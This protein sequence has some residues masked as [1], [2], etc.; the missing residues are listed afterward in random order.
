MNQLARPIAAITVLVVS[1]VGLAD[2]LNLV[3]RDPDIMAGFLTVDYQSDTGQLTLSGYALT[4]TLE[5][6]QTFNIKAPRPFQINARITNDGTATDGTLSV[7]GKVTVGAQVYSGTLVSGT[8]TSFGYRTPGGGALILEFLFTSTGG[9]MSNY[10]NPSR[11]PI[12]VIATANVGAFQGFGTGFTDHSL[13][14]SADVYQTP[15]PPAI[16]L[17]LMGLGA[18][19]VYRRVGLFRFRRQG[20]SA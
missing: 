10:F 11:G 14:G 5:G 3:P 13:A 18:I 12:G 1:S 9:S 7:M 8:L 17:G 15:S 6:D 16:L 19:A 20:A 2:P 4:I